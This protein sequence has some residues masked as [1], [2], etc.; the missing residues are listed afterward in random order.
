MYGTAVTVTGI[1]ISNTFFFFSVRMT[2]EGILHYGADG[3]ARGL[4]GGQLEEAAESRTCAAAS[5]WA[6]LSGSRSPSTPS[7]TVLIL[8]PSVK[9]PTWWPFK[10]YIPT[11]GETCEFFPH[12][13]MWC[14]IASNR[15]R[16]FARNV[17]RRA[18]LTETKIRLI[19]GSPGSFVMSGGDYS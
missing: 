3:H 12:G 14:S 11:N 8:P 5:R 10:K 7:S 4:E 17:V 13:A 2:W 15:K 6:R 9:M 19:G 16:R 1:S 18:L